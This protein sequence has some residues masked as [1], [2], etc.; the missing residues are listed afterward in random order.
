MKNY[1]IPSNKS[2]HG[3]KYVS[4]MISL[5]SKDNSGSTRADK[6]TFLI[7]CMLLNEQKQGLY[8]S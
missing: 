8:F 7:T 4:F 6:V 3:Y 1:V 5:L 2:E